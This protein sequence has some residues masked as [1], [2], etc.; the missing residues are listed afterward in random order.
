MTARIKRS[1]SDT[2]IPKKCT[3]IHMSIPRL[4][5]PKCCYRCWNVLD[6]FSSVSLSFRINFR[7]ALFFLLFY[8][9]AHVCVCVRARER[10]ET[11]LDS[12]L[13]AN[14]RKSR[15]AFVPAFETNNSNVYR[16]VELTE[17][18]VCLFRI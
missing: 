17:V 18:L 4:L 11:G 8:E 7:R 6:F 3:R 15:T 5:G 14:D 9:S 16:D 2:R 10:T 13:D 1:P 12:D